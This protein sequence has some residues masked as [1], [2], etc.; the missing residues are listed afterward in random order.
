MRRSSQSSARSAS[1]CGRSSWCDPAQID[2][3]AFDPATSAAPKRDRPLKV[4]LWYPASRWPRAQSPRRT[5]EPVRRAAGAADTLHS[6]RHRGARRQGQPRADFP[7]HRLAR[8][9]TTMR[10]LLSWLTGKPRVEGYVVAAIPPC[11]SADHGSAAKFPELLLRRPLDIA[12]VARTLHALA[13]RRAPHRS[14]A[15]RADRLLDGRIRRARRRRAA[16]WIRKVPSSRWFRW[17]ADALCARRRANARTLRVADV[18]AVVAIS[19]RGRLAAEPGVRTDFRPSPS[20]LLLIAGDRDGTVDYET[21]RARVLRPGD[22]QQPLPADVPGRRPPHRPRA[23]ARGNASSPV[24]PGLVR[25]S[26]LGIGAH[27][28]HQPAFHHGFPRPLREGRF[29]PRGLS[30]WADAQIERRHLAGRSR[31]TIRR[32]QSRHGWHHAVE[33]IP[34]PAR[35]GLELRHEAP[36]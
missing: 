25:G 18:K 20:P 28:R 4:E 23:R 2:V 9:Q 14:V 33:G 7:G 10:S 13:R 5:R 12:F 26:R 11:R 35:R 3:L 32:V 24:G 1:V 31:R 29:E 19:P 22:E 21:G 8:L 6:P 34:A 15:H 30:R 17:S 27:R 36:R 16:N